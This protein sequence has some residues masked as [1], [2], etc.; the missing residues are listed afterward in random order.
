[1]PLPRVVARLNKRYTNRLIEPIVRRFSGFA[2]VGHVG[3]RSG[4]A[5]R[6]PVNVFECRGSLVVALTY[7]SSADWA[8]NVLAGGGS[9]RRR[10]IDFPIE[11]ASVVGRD[12]AWSCMPALV[13][14]ALRI[15]RVR[16]FMWIEVARRPNP[17]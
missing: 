4:A 16:E 7:G 12:H 9:V 11:S 17:P 10:D 15:L 8:Q 6:T 13:R 3:R 14:V 2:I 5:Y 1:M